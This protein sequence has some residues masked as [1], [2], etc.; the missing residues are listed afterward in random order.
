MPHRDLLL[1]VRIR[2]PRIEFDGDGK[3][4]RRALCV[5]SEHACTRTDKRADLSS[6]NKVRPA[7]LD[8]TSVRLAAASQRLADE[9]QFHLAHAATKTVH[10]NE[11]HERKHG[12]VI[13]HEDM[14]GNEERPW[15]PATPVWAD[16][17]RCEYVLKRFCARRRCS[18]PGSWQLASGSAPTRTRAPR[19]GSS[20]P[21]CTRPAHTAHR[22][23]HTFTHATRTHTEATEPIS[24]NY[25]PRIHSARAKW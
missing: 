9:R 2:R 10:L 5:W 17:R 6:A 3:C 21:R 25:N 18:R 15:V 20:A 4:L 7:S 12:S 24:G 8:H 16:P 1:V 14:D 19:H 13:T 22:C 23:M 11:H